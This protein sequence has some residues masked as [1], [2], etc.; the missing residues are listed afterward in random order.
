MDRRRIGVGFQT[1]SQVFSFAQCPA[2]PMGT[3]IS[4]L[5]PKLRERK[6]DH[7]NLVPSLRIRGTIP[8][9]PRTYSYGSDKLALDCSCS[10]HE[11]EKKYIVLIGNCVDLRMI[12]KWMLGS[13]IQRCGLGSGSGQHRNEPFEYHKMRG[14]LGQVEHILASGTWLP[15]TC[16][17]PWYFEMPLAVF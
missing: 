3:G 16:S 10:T 14:S 17:E 9:F 2:R 11:R 1:R 15:S 8:F 4:P 12:L 7:F 5:G 6:S 13:R